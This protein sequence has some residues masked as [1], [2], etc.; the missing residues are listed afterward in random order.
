MGNCTITEGCKGE[1]IKKATKPDHAIGRPTLPEAGIK[2]WERRRVLHDHVQ[3]FVDS[4]WVIQHNL[5]SHPVTNVFVDHEDDQG[6]KSLVEYSNFELTHVTRDVLKLNF[7][8][9]RSGRVQCIVRNTRDVAVEEMIAP[10]IQAPIQSLQLTATRLGPGEI[11]FA[12][13]VPTNVKYYGVSPLEQCAVKLQ[14]VSMTD[15]NI[16]LEHRMVLK[17]IG[18]TPVDRLRSP[19]SDVPFVQINGD[20][21]MVR[22]ANIHPLNR[23]LKNLGVTEGCKCIAS[24]VHPT[25]GSTIVPR[26]Y[27]YILLANG[28]LFTPVDV[29]LDKLVDFESIQGQQVLT[30]K[31][32]SIHLDDVE[33]ISL[34]HPNILPLKL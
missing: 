3:D 33:L 22:S 12:L 4:E 13:K 21:Y 29:V 30:F 7:P 10:Q 1:L 24:F 19:W 16:V 17:D 9:V 32:Q 15:G 25:S 31:D 8:T 27:M 28:P 26:G 6:I 20:R 11:T 14:F 34:P 18:S 5:G 2:D 23:T